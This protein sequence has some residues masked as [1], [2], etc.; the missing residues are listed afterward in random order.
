MP[1]LKHTKWYKRGLN[2]DSLEVKKG[3]KNKKWDNV[4]H[5]V[6]DQ[7]KLDWYIQND[8]PLDKLFDELENKYKKNGDKDL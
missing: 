7:D 1:N 5:K 4:T 6:M 2:G 8:L 3:W